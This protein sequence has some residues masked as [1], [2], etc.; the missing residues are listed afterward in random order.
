MSVD[1]PHG[2]LPS[3][4]MSSMAECIMKQATQFTLR[5]TLQFGE[6]YSIY[7][8]LVKLYV[9]EFAHVELQNR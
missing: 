3:H 6:A 5:G 1:W 4:K 7:I 8:L 9:C 2:H